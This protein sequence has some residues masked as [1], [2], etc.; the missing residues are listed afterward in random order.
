MVARGDWRWAQRLYGAIAL[1]H[2]SHHKK[3]MLAL[4]LLYEFYTKKQTRDNGFCTYALTHA[5]HLLIL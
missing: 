4:Y 3:R 5:L 2:V 1:Q